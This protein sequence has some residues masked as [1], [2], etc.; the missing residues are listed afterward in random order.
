VGPEGPRR[1]L[2]RPTAASLVALAALLVSLAGTGWA[3]F[4]LPSG[5]VGSAQLRAGA[6]TRP[7]LAV[8][9]AGGRQLAAGSVTRFA[10]RRAGVGAFQIDRS[11][12]QTRVARGCPAGT[13]ISSVAAGGTVGCTATLPQGYDRGSS[14]I[15]LTSGQ[16]VIAIKQLEGGSS[17]LAIA[18]AEVTVKG[19]VPRQTVQVG[20]ALESGQPGQV[21]RSGS[22]RFEVGMHTR[23]QAATIPLVLPVPRMPGTSTVELR[24]S[25][26]FAPSTA[27]P[28][29]S[30]KTTIDAVQT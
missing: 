14:T 16:R 17:F 4:Q 30:V 18:Y 11:Q 6:V 15:R 25:H 13:A 24:C 23:T 12:V 1:R 9:T 2:R 29:V 8:G 27:A 7:K 21:V 19:S 20:C 5:S 26:S 28:T 3:A 10:L 22:L